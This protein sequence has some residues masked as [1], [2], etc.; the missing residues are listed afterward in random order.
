MRA[1][2]CQS[3]QLLHIMMD[4]LLPCTLRPLAAPRKAQESPASYMYSAS[5]LLEETLGGKAVARSGIRGGASQ[6]L[7][8]PLT[9]AELGVLGATKDGVGTQAGAHACPRSQ[10]LSHW[11]EDPLSGWLHTTGGEH[12]IIRE[13]LP[14]ERVTVSVT[15]GCFRVRLQA[16]LAPGTPLGHL[17]L[18]SHSYR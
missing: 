3:Q 16:L 14:A 2:A 18:R 12:S 4:G 5:D 13:V 17:I 6:L 15:T 10:L 7:P 11:C 8:G 9:S 1:Q